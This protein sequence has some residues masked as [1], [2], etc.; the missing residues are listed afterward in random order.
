MRLVCPSEL[1]SEPNVQDVAALTGEAAANA[2]KPVIIQVNR[3][4]PELAALLCVVSYGRYDT[5]PPASDFLVDVVIVFYF[6][7]QP[8]TR[9]RTIN[10]GYY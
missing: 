2:S 8:S 3:R 7:D 6:S 10:P 4:L 9:S 5:E 1:V